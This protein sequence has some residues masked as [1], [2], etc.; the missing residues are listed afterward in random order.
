MDL[1]THALV[2][3]A[4]RRVNRMQLGIFTACSVLGAILP[5]VGEILIQQAL[6]KKYGANLAVYDSRTSDFDISTQLEITGLYDVTH[7]LFTTFVLFFIGYI[8]L[9][10]TKRVS[11]YTTALCILWFAFGQFSHVCLD[12]FTHGKVWA[13]KLFY[14]ISNYRFMILSDSVGNWWDWKPSFMIPLLDFPFPI[15]C[16]FIWIILVAFIYIKR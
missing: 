5:D 4:I 2:G 10:Q 12:S 9:K 8:L 15:Y 6:S 7:S 11:A 16:C 13:L 14:P 1:F 3:V